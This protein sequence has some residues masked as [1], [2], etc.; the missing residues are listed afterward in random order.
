MYPR[1]VAGG[2]AI[3]FDFFAFGLFHDIMKHFR[4]R[5][6]SSEIVLRTTLVNSM[7]KESNVFSVSETFLGEQAEMPLEETGGIGQVG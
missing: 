4:L 3:I 6:W 1:L 2:N 5:S 7:P